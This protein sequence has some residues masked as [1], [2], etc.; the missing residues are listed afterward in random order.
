ME[1]H[2]T[3]DTE[4]K[5]KDLASQS[6]RGTDDLIEDAVAGYFDE[7]LRAHEALDRRYDELKSGTVTAI[8][9]DDIIDHFREKS[10][11]RR[12]TPRS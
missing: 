8:S 6:G 7:V 11:A 3:P 9:R 2:L 4:K 1:V 10:D 12:S 5:L